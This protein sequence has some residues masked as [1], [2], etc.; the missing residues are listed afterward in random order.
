MK[1]YEC[2]MITVLFANISFIH[3]IACVVYMIMTQDMG[4]PFKNSLTEE[5]IEIKRKAVFE[6]RK[7][8]NIGC[9]IGLITILL[10]KPFSKGHDRGRR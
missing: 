3:L 8:Y 9:T 2:S 5:Q 7:I 1:H 10:W 4:T 6:R